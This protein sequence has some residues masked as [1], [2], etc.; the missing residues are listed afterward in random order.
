[1]K[2]FMSDSY[3][4]Y[5]VGNIGT[6]TVLDNAYSP[7][8]TSLFTAYQT[9][10]GSILT[11]LDAH[12]SMSFLTG[13]SLNTSSFSWG[14]IPWGATFARKYRFDIK[15]IDGRNNAISGARVQLLN[16]AGTSQFDTTTAASGS[17]SQQQVLVANYDN[18]KSFIS[19]N[20]DTGADTITFA[21]AHGFTTT[22]AVGLSSP[23]GGAPGGLTS[24]TTYYVIRV[25]DTVIKLATSSAN[26]TAGTA[27]D[28]T[29]QG[30][31]TSKLGL[32][33][34]HSTETSFNPFTLKVSASGYKP[35]ESI[36]TIDVK[37]DFTIKLADALSNNQH[38]SVLLTT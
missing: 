17:I 25:S 31:G 37:K 1:M 20:V 5:G 6:A 12:P 23:T 24:G 9:P 14:G 28:L 30:T 8:E 18:G 15:A 2:N 36:I 29:S 7:R 4:V 32:N 33:S 16:N 10:I 3:I 27:I 38:Q 11:V 26:A 22:N 19:T 21:S 34:Y 13:T 35:Y